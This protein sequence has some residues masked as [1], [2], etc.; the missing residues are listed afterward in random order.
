[1]SSKRVRAIIASVKKEEQAATLAKVYRINCQ[2]CANPETQPERNEIGVWEHMVYSRVSGTKVRE[3]R[4]T[5]ILEVFR[6][7]GE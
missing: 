4:N 5:F 2:H 3:C 6:G 7:G 1:M